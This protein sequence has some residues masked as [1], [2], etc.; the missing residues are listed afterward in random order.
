[1]G[2]PTADHFADDE[3]CGKAPEHVIDMVLGVMR[4]RARPGA[5]LEPVAQA[6]A[7]RAEAKIW[8]DRIWSEAFMAGAAWWAAREPARMLV[9]PERFAEIAEAA[10][11]TG[12]L[13]GV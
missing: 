10:E 13:P 2:V 4:Q 8:A 6:R 5:G 12:R 1:M 3:S 9:A 11:T 7:D